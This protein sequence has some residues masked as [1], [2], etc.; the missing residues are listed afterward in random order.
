MPE[1]ITC[2]RAGAASSRAAVPVRRL[3]PDFRA[4][5]NTAAPIA[6]IRR[7]GGSS[8]QWGWLRGR[9]WR[10]DGGSLPSAAALFHS[11]ATFISATALVSAAAALFPA[12][13]AP[14]AAAAAS[15]AVGWLAAATALIPRA[16]LL[17]HLDRFRRHPSAI[18]ACRLRFVPPPV[19]LGLSGP[20]C[21]G[22]HSG[23]GR[24]PLRRR[25]RW[26]RRVG[27]AAPVDISGRRGRGGG[28]DAR[29]GKMAGGSGR[30]AALL[31][32]G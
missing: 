6:P 10:G 20:S 2:H 1:R 25:R 23:A 32:F 16:F 31:D 29:L 14:V 15:F 9:A 18:A 8:W 17:L 26:R 7:R 27:V 24:S 21:L 12:A 22:L 4:S 13:A 30:R 19:R 3:P 28:R 5:W 11:A